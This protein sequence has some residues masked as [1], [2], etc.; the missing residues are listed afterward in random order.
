MNLFGWVGLWLAVAGLAVVAIE[1]LVL[2]PG[3]LRLTKR[4]NQLTLLLEQQVSLTRD[5]LQALQG[6]TTER[7]ALLR[8]YRRLWRWLRHPLALALLRSYWRRR[9]RSSTPA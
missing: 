3:F 2:V 7:S 4:L 1:L 5:E 9:A 6:S 8:P